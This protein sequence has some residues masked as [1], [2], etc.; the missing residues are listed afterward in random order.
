MRD[1]GVEV[2]PLHQIT[3]ESDF[4]EVFFSDVFIPEDRIIGPENE[5]WQVANPTLTH[6]RGVNPRQ[7]VVH[8]QLV[9]ELLRLATDNG[10]FDDERGRAAPGGGVRRG[11]DLPAA[12]LAFDLAH[13]EGRGT[14][15][16]SAAST[17]S[18]GAR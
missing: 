18:G 16:P 10:A 14:R 2:R 17:R 5:G 3:D 8:T 11:P 7:L 13:C 9:E 1:P 12:Q 6:E 15:D 4:N